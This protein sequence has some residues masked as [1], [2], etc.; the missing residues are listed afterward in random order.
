MLAR[1]IVNM[2]TSLAKFEDLMCKPEQLFSVCDPEWTRG[3]VVEEMEPGHVVCYRVVKLPFPLKDRDL[4][5]YAYR[6]MYMI[7]HHRYHAMSKPTKTDIVVIGKSVDHH[8]RPAN[9]KC[10][11]GDLMCMCYTCHSLCCDVFHR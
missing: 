6:D 11:R 4:C 9:D 7:L 10:V 1:G 8:K 5:W 3:E 2:E